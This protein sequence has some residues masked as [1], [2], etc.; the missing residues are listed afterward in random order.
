MFKKLVITVLFFSLILNSEAQENG[1]Q[2]DKQIS[3]MPWPEKVEVKA[4]GFKIGNDFS[5]YI[6]GDVSETSRIYKAAVRFIRNATDKTG[7]FV[8]EGFP[9]TDNITSESASLNIHFDQEAK[10]E[11]G[12]DESYKLSV[13]SDGIEIHAVTDIGAMHGLSS[14]LQLIEVQGGHYE[15][16]GVEI[17]DS[18]RFVW[19]GLMMDVSRH[20]MP[21]EVVKRNLDAMA[22]VKLNVFHWHLSDDQG[23]RIE[24]KT[25]PELYEKAS[26]G[27]YYTQ[28]EIRDI[29]RYADDRG[30]RVIPELDV[31]GHGTAFL[32]AFPEFGS[33]EGMTYSV[34]RNSG[35]F[36]PTLDPTN[37]KV[38]EF[39]DIL[40]KEVTAL[41]PDVYFHIGGDENAGRHW[42]ENPKIQQ[43]MKENNLKDNHELQTYFNIKLQKILEKYG[44]SLMG[45]EEIMTENMPKTALIH[46]WRGVNEG[47]QPGESL[48]KAVKNGYQTILSNGY[49]IDLMLSV[50]E[51]YVV[52]P[53]PAV[54]LTKEQSDRILGGEATMWAELVTPL[55]VDS[56]IWPRTAAIAE[57]F[58]SPQEVRDLESMHNRL[59]V[60]NQYL[61]LIGIRNQQVQAYLLRN[62]SNYQDTHALRQLVNISEPFEI[63]SRNDGGTQYQTYS[64]FTLFADACT[65]DA[66]D[67]RRFNKLVTKYI[68][69][70]DAASKE[71]L[72]SM[73][74]RYASIEGSLESIASDAPLVG[75]VLPYAKRVSNIATLTG[76]GLEEGMLSA[77]DLEGLKTLLGQKEDPAINLDVELALSE[78]FQR[79]AEFLAK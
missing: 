61:E 11:Q 22:L 1:M 67:K 44:K 56:R 75:R 33:K 65:A 55:T 57:R 34:E 48:V 42:D 15:F 50:E 2:E 21:V 58:W 18:P 12:I 30:I 38:Y 64:P 16:K 19:R 26:D 51:H 78:D 14:L 49:Y 71:K 39:L 52:D 3:L 70:Q 5:I 4:S 66:K 47:M 24:T 37:E 53:M 35:I 74:E 77:S 40:F 45:W 62:I 32:T 68:E 46:S 63:Y 25:L 23:F 20:F 28:E 72:V 60:V 10:V 7:V 54:E 73:L 27:L 29:V 13:G 8:A 31:P 76:K 79:L 17:Q 41:F 59:E 6:H 9:N 36:D 43:F 69:I